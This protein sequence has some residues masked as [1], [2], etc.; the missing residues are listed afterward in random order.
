MSRS[1]A[2]PD[3]VRVRRLGAT[4]LAGSLCVSPLFAEDPLARSAARE[5]SRLA[6]EPVRVIP[7]SRSVEQARQDKSWSRVQA[8]S[9]G[10]RIVVTEKGGLARTDYYFVATAADYISVDVDRDAAV[11][12]EIDR[13]VIGEI[14]VRRSNTRIGALIGGGLIVLPGLANHASFDALILVGGLWAGFG[15]L[16][17]GNFDHQHVIFRAP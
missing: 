12:R 16:V 9:P 11:H 2:F 13:S 4:L 3:E 14:A 8:L 6:A 10:S 7:R 5:V 15:A 17:G 1:V